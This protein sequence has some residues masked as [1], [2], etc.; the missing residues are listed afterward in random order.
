MAKK[1]KV[2]VV[3][4]VGSE[5]K[6]RIAAAGLTGVIR[7]AEEMPDLRVH[8]VST[9]F[10]RLD[11]L[12]SRFQPGMPRGFDCEIY[13]KKPSDGKTTLALQIASHWQ[14][15]GFRIAILDLERTITENYLKMLNIVMANVVIDKKEVHAPIFVRPEKEVI[16]VE[17]LL[18]S[19]KFLS[20]PLGGNVDMI[21]VDSVGVMN[22]QK[23]LEKS[24]ADSAQFGGIAGVLTD[25]MKKNIAK[26]PTILWLNQAKQGM[27]AM[28]G[29]PA[30]Y[31]TVGGGA[32][33][34]WSSIRI[35]LARIKTFK[36]EESEFGFETKVLVSKNKMGRDNCSIAMTY[37]PGEGFSALL[38][39]LTVAKD[40][41]IVVK[42][43]SWYQAGDRKWQGDQQLYYAFKQDTGL[44]QWLCD[45]V[46]EAEI[47]FT[48][49]EEPDTD[50]PEGA[51]AEAERGA[52]AA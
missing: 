12:I 5:L 52:E 23:N 48:V 28:P 11:R 3:P 50:T 16:P 33:K 40:L 17:M 39:Y 46:N 7:L 38:D 49:T 2:E 8:S 36:P 29:L 18:D 19:I 4:E 9:G 22:T 31:K 21:V 20:D 30:P 14:K 32:L 6:K 10:F 47:P 27:A 25:F 41:G 24:S 35:E 15:L 51:A 37:I 43:G 42:S 26:L 44:Y 13:S 34:F 1:P 45:A